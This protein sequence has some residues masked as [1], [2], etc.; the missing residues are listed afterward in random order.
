VRCFILSCAC[1]VACAQPK[2]VQD[3]LDYL[4]IGV[5]PHQEADAIIEDLR[6]HGFA[7]GRRIDERD[8]VA[9]DAVR[10]PDSTVRV[11]T[12]R[13][14]ALSIQAPD[15]RWP[16]RL[17]VE[18][19]PDPRPDFDRDGRR[20]VVVALRERERTCFAWAQ[21]D[22]AG[23]VSEVFRPNSDWGQSPCVL[24]I[25]ADWPRLLLEVSVP[26][27][28]APDARVRLPVKATARSWVL[29]DSPAAGARW[30]SETEHRKV[31]LEE[32]EVRNDLPTA[33][34]LRAELRW[35][36]R[37]RKAKEPVL[38]AAEDGEEAR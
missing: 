4:Q 9:F 7:I 32:A 13:G 12:S 6:V 30:E 22:A 11:V 28:P 15:A 37:L 23:F 17:W 31:A 26:D 3:P 36:Q 33:D 16:G 27:S 19:G 5:D 35:L 38:E 14:S 24:E 34:R 2:P 25:D 8:F 21:V 10:G 1:L 20:D 18:L 29:D